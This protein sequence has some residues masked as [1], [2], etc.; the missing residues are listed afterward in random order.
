MT[1]QEKK[2]FIRYTIEDE[3]RHLEY[4]CNSVAEFIQRHAERMQKAK[5]DGNL[6]AMA[7]SIDSIRQEAASK[8]AQIKECAARIA[9]Y[10]NAEKLLEK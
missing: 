8:D 5:Q 3:T 7:D 1:E 6:C 10:S 4:L 2:C 9:A